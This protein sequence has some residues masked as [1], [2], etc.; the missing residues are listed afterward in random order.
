MDATRLAVYGVAGIVLAVTLVSGPLVGAVDL[1]Q[2]PQACS[3]PVGTGTA[4]VSVDSLPDSA[5]ISKGEFGSEVYYLQVPDGSATVENV[6]GQPTLSYTISIPELGRTA[7][8]VLFLCADQ[9]ARQPLSIDRR[10]IE[11]EDL[12]AD[13]YEATLTLLLRGD[14][15]ETLVREKAITVEV[16]Q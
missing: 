12:T 14:G 5:T 15:G 7:G 10:T 2:E 9:S 13:S 4:T 8:P 1:T 6:T 3:A 16:E 11:E